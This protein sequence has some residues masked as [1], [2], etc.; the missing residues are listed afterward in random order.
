LWQARV[1]L[2]RDIEKALG[3]DPAGEIAQALAERWQTQLDEASGGDAEIKAAL[4]WG[5][6]NRQNWPPSMR[7][8]VE[9]LHMMSF[10][11]FEKAA[12]FLDKAAGT[13]QHGAAMTTTRRDH[14]ETLLSAFLDETA[15]TRKILERLP[16]DKL[17]WKPHEKSFPLGKL[18]NHVAAIPVGVALVITG[19]G[20]KPSEV[21]SRAELLAVFDQRTAAAREAL[22]GTND[23]HLAGTIHVTPAIKKTRSAALMWMMSHLIHH[24]GQLSVY[25]RLLDV[26]VPGM[27]GPSADEKP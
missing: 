3:E 4:L 21:A 19:Q 15:N 7:W 1:D 12:D 20:S 6:E 27:Y 26:P 2:F 25:L 14:V 17:A 18:A 13:L 5:W 10:E 24:R 16:E 11:R 22:A 23:D 9:A 8:Q